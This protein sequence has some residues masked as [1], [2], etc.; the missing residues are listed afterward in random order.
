MS[1]LKLNYDIVRSSEILV[2]LTKITPRFLNNNNNNN[3][4]LN[5]LH[6]RSRGNNL[7]DN[8]NGI[9]HNNDVLTTF[10]VCYNN[11]CISEI[12]ENCLHN[13]TA[14]YNSDFG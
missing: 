9:I 6:N 13:S 1:H 3:S 12:S 8:E 11:S 14:R 7:N 4:L 10:Q 5:I 2:D